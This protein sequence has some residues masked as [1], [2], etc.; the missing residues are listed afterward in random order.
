MAKWQAAVFGG[1]IAVAASAA[2]TAALAAGF[3]DA[4]GIEAG[5]RVA[6]IGQWMVSR[7]KDG[8]GCIAVYPYTETLSVAVAGH[9][10]DQL[11]LVV[12]VNRKAFASP[13]ETDASLIELV[14][15]KEER[16]GFQPIA[17]RETPSFLMQADDELLARMAT[18]PI[19]KITEQG[20]V[21]AQF[22][23]PQMA[24]AIGKLSQCL[25]ETM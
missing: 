6:K 19:V 4:V 22:Q 11:A 24:Q 3:Q 18:A 7:G 20:F 2:M 15:G 17:Y 8:A 23:V 1:A 5:E 21:R 13:I 25:T 16:P 10:W 14:L 12:M 9:S